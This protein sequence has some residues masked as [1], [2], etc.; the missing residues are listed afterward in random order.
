[1]PVVGAAQPQIIV[2]QWRLARAVGT[3]SGPHAD[4]DLST[5]GDFLTI[6]KVHDNAVLATLG[7]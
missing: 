7:S 1:M 5:I 6:R 2:G 3:G 4:A